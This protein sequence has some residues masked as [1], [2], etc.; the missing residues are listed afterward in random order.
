[1]VI[2]G[3]NISK[4]ASIT[5]HPALRQ[6]LNATVIHN[7]E[8]HYLI[9]WIMTACRITLLNKS[10]VPI[11]VYGPQWRNFKLGMKEAIYDYYDY[12]FESLDLVK[13]SAGM[14]VLILQQVPPHQYGTLVSILNPLAASG[15]I[16]QQITQLVADPGGD[17]APSDHVQYPNAGRSRGP[18]YT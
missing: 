3:P 12:D 1:M 6:M 15:A 16:I 2:N 8:N 11:L 17:R 9:K 7:N 13:F 5:T 10:D 18:P 14:R 4:L